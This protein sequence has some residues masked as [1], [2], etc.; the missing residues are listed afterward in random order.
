MN[1]E[2]KIAK[3]KFTKII[4]KMNILQ[5]NLLTSKNKSLKDNYS[6]G[7]SCIENATLKAY[8]KFKKKGRKTN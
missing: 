3:F 6:T 2:N 8:L 4:C 7:K 5:K 1:G